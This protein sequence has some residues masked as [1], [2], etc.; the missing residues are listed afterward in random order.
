[1]TD[2]M[3]ISRKLFTEQ[4]L[5]R[6]LVQISVGKL[7]LLTQVCSGFLQSLQR[8]PGMAS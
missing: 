8:N 4:V 2:I 6:Y 5:P 1:M 3:C 7:T